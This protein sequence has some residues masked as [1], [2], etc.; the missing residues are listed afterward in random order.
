LQTIL[1]KYNLVSSNRKGKS[2]LSLFS[3]KKK[4]NKEKEKQK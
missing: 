3:K 2:T 1:A 4:E